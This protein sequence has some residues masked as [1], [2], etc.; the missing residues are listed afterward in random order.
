MATDEVLSQ[1]EISTLLDGMSSGEIPAGSYGG[2]KGEVLPFDFSNIEHVLLTKMPRLDMINELFVDGFYTSLSKLFKSEPVL[3]LLPVRTRSFSDYL[4]SLASPVNINVV[5]ISPLR[6]SS[7]IVLDA[8]LLHLLVDQY[9]GGLG[10]SDY[11]DEERAFSPIELRISQQVLQIVFTEL[12]HAWQ[13]TLDI[14]IVHD[15]TEHSPDSAQVLKP[16]EVILQVSLQVGYGDNNGEL[17]IVFPYS[18]LESVRD[19]LSTT[20]KE[21]QQADDA[22]WQTLLGNELNS[23]PVG[24]SS[25]LGNTQITLRE[26]IAL[27]PGD[28]LP[29]EMP[30]TVSIF[31]ED[32]PILRGHFGASNGKNAVQICG[33]ET[34]DV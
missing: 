5:H 26:L 4:Q 24:V 11:Q 34:K 13:D 2:V 22:H 25:T 12:Q 29:I 9:F 30:E 28:V 7:L 20:Q 31:V 17:H 8:K 10:R 23:A 18:M 6:G 21:D 1:E 33:I 3:S 32:I 19:K 27:S 15:S 16:N 14:S